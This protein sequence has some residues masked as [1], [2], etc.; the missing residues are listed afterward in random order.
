M[1]LPTDSE[2]RKNAP[3][4]SG[5]MAYWPDAIVAVAMLSKVGNDKHNPG[6]K[7]HWSRGKSDDHGDCIGRHQL[8]F[9]QWNEADRCW[10]ATNVAWR[11]MCQLQVLLEMQKG[12]ACD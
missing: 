11:A 5:F 6:E 8:E 4:Y 7:I 10:H 3:V 1:T 12:R 9:D 2:E